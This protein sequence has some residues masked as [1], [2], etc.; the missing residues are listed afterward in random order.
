ME[1][2]FLTIVWRQACGEPDSGKLIRGDFLV[3]PFQDPQY[4]CAG[5]REVLLKQLRVDNVQIVPNNGGKVRIHRRPI[6]HDTLILIVNLHEKPP[7]PCVV[8]TLAQSAKGDRGPGKIASDPGGFIFRD[9]L[10]GKSQELSKKLFVGIHTQSL[11][12]IVALLVPCLRGLPQLVMLAV[13]RLILPRLHRIG[14]QKILACPLS[15]RFRCCSFWMA[16]TS[17]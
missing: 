5:A 8:G 15:I 6:E 16:R 9:I 2:S 3:D 14:N 12:G 10:G 1:V 11:H 13:S 17:L 7:F 4:G